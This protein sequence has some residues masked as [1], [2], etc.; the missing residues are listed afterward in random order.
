MKQSEKNGFHVEGNRE[1]LGNV[2][3]LFGAMTDSS[4]FS[5]GFPNHASESDRVAGCVEDFIARNFG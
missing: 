4:M 5:D 2:K 1:Q 3:I